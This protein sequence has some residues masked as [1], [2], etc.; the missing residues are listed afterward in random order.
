MFGPRRGSSVL[1]LVFFIVLWLGAVGF[2]LYGHNRKSGLSKDAEPKSLQGKIDALKYDPDK[3]T[4]NVELLLGRLEGLKKEVLY[5]GRLLG[6]GLQTATPEQGSQEFATALAAAIQKLND[7]ANQTDAALPK[8]TGK[9]VSYA[10]LFDDTER[11][12][13]PLGRNFELVMASL[14]DR[15]SGYEE[16]LVYYRSLRARVDDSTERAGRLEEVYRSGIAKTDE[17]NETFSE[18]KGAM[19]GARFEIPGKVSSPSPTVPSPGERVTADTAKI[20]REFRDSQKGAP[21]TFKDAQDR[22]ILEMTTFLATMVTQKIREYQQAVAAEETTIDGLTKE[23]NAEQSRLSTKID[24]AVKKRHRGREPGGAIRAL[25]PIP[26]Q[27][28]SPPNE[29]PSMAEETADAQVVVVS[30]ETDEIY[31]DI[32]DEDGAVEGLRLFVYR[33][34]P[35]KVWMYRGAVTVKKVLPKMSVASITHQVSRFDP[36][37]ANDSAFNKLFDPAKPV[38]IVLLGQVDDDDLARYQHLVGR[39]GASLDRDVSVLTDYVVLFGKKEEEEWAKH[40]GSK[41]NVERAKELGILGL[42]EEEFRL[43]IEH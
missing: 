22:A 29:A 25:P 8:L 10:Q 27:S 17:A 35:Q 2:V 42:Y 9:S 38:R 7:Y 14:E 21:G 34:G 18:A 13:A 12:T 24:T 31:L 11:N 37:A 30:P 32:G 33:P 36:I 23:F 16:Q 26:V 3:E 28:L 15:L 19:A 40:P 5:L 43:Y 20:S 1:G 41:D 6:Y 4:E 39:V